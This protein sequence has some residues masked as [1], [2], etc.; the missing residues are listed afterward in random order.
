[1]GE[2]LFFN[3]IWSWV[4]QSVQSNSAS[5]L[6]Y[7]GHSFKVLYLS[8]R[9]GISA[10]IWKGERGCDGHVCEHESDLK[11][12]GDGRPHEAQKQREATLEM[13]ICKRGQS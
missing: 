7:V 8:V 2:N 9:F 4:T 11:V 5:S 13:A 12:C 10:V 1:M 6:S 3:I